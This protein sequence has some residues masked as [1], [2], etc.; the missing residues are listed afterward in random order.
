MPFLERS[1]E[2]EGACAAPLPGDGG[3]AA[4][5][6]MRRCETAS[7]RSSRVGTD[8]TPTALAS[9]M[10]PVLPNGVNRLLP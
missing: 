5:R 3:D 4:L 6:C 2:A 1:C 7:F 8:E 10:A 9:A